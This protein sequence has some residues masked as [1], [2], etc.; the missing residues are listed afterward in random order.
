MITQRRLVVLL[1][2]IIPYLVGKRQQALL[3]YDF[4][5][6]RNLRYTRHWYE[7]QE[8]DEVAYNECIKLNR[9]GR[10][11]VESIG[12]TPSKEGEDVLRTTEESV[13]AAEMTA[14]QLVN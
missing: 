3:L 6:R 14:R 12:E 13:E 5:L 2:K 11:T 8:K 4:C 1:P 7:F 9:R 10:V